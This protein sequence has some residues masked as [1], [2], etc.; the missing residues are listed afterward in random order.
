MTRIARIVRP[1][2]P[3][4]WSMPWAFT[5]IEPPTVK[6]SV[7]CIAVTAKRGWRKVWTACQVAPLSTVNVRVWASSDIRF[8]RVM[9]S[10]SALR[11]KACPP[12]LC[13]TPATDTLSP[14]SRAKCSAART[15]STS[16]TAT[17]P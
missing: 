12:M 11:A 6:M 7:D 13:L 1:T 17:T 4:W 10:T 3:A 9:S 8:S 15:S 5:A 14:L 16:R 2:E